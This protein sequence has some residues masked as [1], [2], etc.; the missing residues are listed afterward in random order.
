MGMIN[1]QILIDDAK[2]FEMV[3]QM[4]WPEGV[5]CAECGSEQVTKNGRDETQHERQRYEC[6]ACERCFDDLTGTVFEGHHQPLKAWVL[7]LYLMGLNL[8]NQQIARELQLNKDDVHAMTRQLREGIVKKKP[9][10]KLQGTIECD[11]V[12]IVAGHKGN[13]AAVEKKGARAAAGV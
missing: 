2:C 3:R 4:R 1:I 12:Y 11:E 7:C 9:L 6:K 8:S 5:R 10:V 13:P